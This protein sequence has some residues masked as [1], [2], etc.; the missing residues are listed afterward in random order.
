LT[1]KNCKNKY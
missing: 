1:C